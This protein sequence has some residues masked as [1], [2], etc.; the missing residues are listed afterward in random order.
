MVRVLVASDVRLYRERLTEILARHP[1]FGIADTV[2]DAAELLPRLAARPADLVL[3]DMAMRGSIAVLL[4]LRAAEPHVKIVAVTVGD[5]E[6][7]VLA[8][9]RAG[10]GG[11]VLRDGSPDDLV[12]VVAS[13]ARA[14]IVCPPRVAAA[15]MRHLATLAPGA[16]STSSPGRL[17]RREGEIVELIDRGLTN[18][19]IARALGV[20]VATVKNHVHNI[21]EKLRVHRRTE[22]AALVRGTATPPVR[23]LNWGA[24]PALDPGPG[25]RA[26]KAHD[27]PGRPNLVPRLSQS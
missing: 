20:E 3:L 16:G 8:C 15:L 14:E 18:K 26:L 6:E 21:L 12:A 9:A 27:D 23:R 1:G 11:Y 10:V 2:A 19:E 25:G 7:E 24:G 4:A 22:A 5:R 17:T 13:V